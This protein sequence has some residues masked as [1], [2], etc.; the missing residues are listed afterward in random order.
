MRRMVTVIGCVVALLAAVVST[1]LAAPTASAASL[2][3]I[4][5]FGNNPSN[6]QMFLYVPNNVRPHPP[7]LVAVHYCGGS[8]PVFFQNTEFRTLADQFGFVVIYPSVTRSSK[9]FDVSSPQ[10][11][12]HN[13][14]SD[15]AGI[16]SMIQYVEQHNNGDASHVYVTGASSG[17]MMTDV[18]LGDY[19]DVFQAGAAFMG[20]PFGCFA[21]TDGS[22]WNTQ[23]ANGQIIKT[24][25]QW[26]DEARAADPGYAGPRP[27]VQLWHGTAD[28]T[29]NFANFGEEIKQ[30][31][32]IWGVSQTPTS[33]TT[34]QSGWTHTTYGS[35]GAVDV[36]AYSIAGAG[37]VL[38]LSGM[39]AIAIHF[40]GLDNSPPPPPPPTTTTTTTHN[41]PPAGVCSVTDAV[42][43]WSTGFTSNLTL[44]NT[45]STAINGWSLGFGLAAGE[46]ITS[47]W[48]AT[49]TPTSGQ[50]TATNMSFNAAIAPGA[51][52]T[53]G[54]QASIT[55]GTAVPPA[56]FTLNGASCA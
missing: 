35:G 47:G 21:T 42:N 56:S 37:H 3:Q 17:A 14:S 30:W 32:N 15:P 48:N 26:G 31:T 34:P 36:D 50:V 43:A 9:C 38:P 20:V 10:A 53:L 27:R 44:T 41:P 29:L 2:V 22:M 23:C 28:G 33:T 7:V 18:L 19:P 51:S 5:N 4:T 13:G 45:G 46:T 25:Q 52:V 8:G 54:F 12:T 40:F 16:F 55:S 49:Y 1:V 24:P 39:A 6:L 11:L